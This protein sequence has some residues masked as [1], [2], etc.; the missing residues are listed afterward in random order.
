MPISRFARRIEFNFSPIRI[1]GPKETQPKEVG[2]EAASP[3]EEPVA[4]GTSQAVTAEQEVQSPVQETDGNKEVVTGQAN[5]D[6]SGNV[7]IPVDAD[8]AKPEC[9][10]CLLT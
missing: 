5:G 9:V 10:F 1:D 7:Q 8:L 4:N 6:A 2:A 3:T